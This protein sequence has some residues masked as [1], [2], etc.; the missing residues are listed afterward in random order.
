MLRV[1]KVYFF[2][3]IR[4]VIL[5]D[6]SNSIQS[7]LDLVSFYPG[8]VMHV[9]TQRLIIKLPKNCKSLCVINIFDEYLII[10]EHL[11]VWKVTN[12][13]DVEEASFCIANIHTIYD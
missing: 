2:S 13:L 5:N 4:I 9:A 12:I 10:K 3:F 1:I 6:S 8:I 11:A 7:M